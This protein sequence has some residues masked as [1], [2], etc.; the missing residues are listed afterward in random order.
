MVLE[1]SENPQPEVYRGCTID[2]F[3]P[4]MRGV[5]VTNQEAAASVQSTRNVIAAGFTGLAEAAGLDAGKISR[6]ISRGDCDG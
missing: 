3:I 2:I 5:A 1:S 6:R 4:L